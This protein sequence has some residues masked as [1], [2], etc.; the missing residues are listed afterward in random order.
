MR[1]ELSV[2][3]VVAQSDGKETLRPAAEIRPNDLLQYTASYTNSGSS[4]AK[5]LVASLPIPSGTQ[6][7]NASALPRMVLASTDGKV[8][9]PVPLMR[10]VKQA[11]G[12]VIEEAVP[13]AEY[14]A[15]RWPEQEVAAGATYTVSTRVRVNALDSSAAALPS[16]TTSTNAA[17][18]SVAAISPNNNTAIR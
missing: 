16:K 7:V 18:T 1:S 2:K 17:S 9:L 8:F 15:L 5:S 12:R 10:K 4:P 6:W 3:Q 13:L 14:R 11:D